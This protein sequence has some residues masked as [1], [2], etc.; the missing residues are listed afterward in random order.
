MKQVQLLHVLNVILRGTQEQ[1]RFVMCRGQLAPHPLCHTDDDPWI[2]CLVPH[3][4]SLQGCSVLNVSALQ[5]LPLVRSEHQFGAI[6]S[7]GSHLLK[8]ALQRGVVLK[9]HRRA[10]LA[11][12]VLISKHLLCSTMLLGMYSQGLPRDCC[13]LAPAETTVDRRKS[14]QEAKTPSSF[15]AQRILLISGLGGRS[16]GGCKRSG[17]ASA[18]F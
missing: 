10:K 13:R 15:A 1:C 18:G 16:P 7:W 8:D 12:V 5:H 2:A 14:P 6:L 11:D 4:R 3:L 17:C 9:A